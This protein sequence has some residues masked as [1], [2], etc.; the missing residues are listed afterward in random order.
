MTNSGPCV[1]NNYRTTLPILLTRDA[2]GS[3]N[4]D[5]MPSGK[6]AP[7]AS[8]L[9][10]CHGRLGPI[11]RKRM[12]SLT[13]WDTRQHP[14]LPMSPAFVGLTSGF[15]VAAAQQASVPGPTV[16]C[17]AA[18]KNSFSAEPFRGT[19]SP[20]EPSCN[21]RMDSFRNARCTDPAATGHPRPAGS[22]RGRWEASSSLARRRC[23]QPAAWA[24]RPAASY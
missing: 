21:R 16:R 17:A 18:F 10:Q 8:S 14:R 12:P 1:N 9:N 3:H 20:R 6:S 23:R 5:P 11:H 4:G 22:D 13:A 15:K 24:C 19:T 7:S 2:P